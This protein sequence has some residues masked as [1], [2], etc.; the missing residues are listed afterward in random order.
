MVNVETEINNKDIVDI[1]YGN[2]ETSNLKTTFFLYFIPKLKGNTTVEF[3]FKKIDNDE[4][5]K[6]IAYEIKVSDT[7][8]VSYSEIE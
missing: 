4:I 1:K 8:E 7:L 6:A 3:S 2:I 5:I